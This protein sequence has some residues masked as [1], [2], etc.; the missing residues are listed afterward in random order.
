MLYRRELVKIQSNFS[1]K[2]K[3]VELQ[4]Q[5]TIKKTESAVKLG[6]RLLTFVQ[7]IQGGET[8]SQTQEVGWRL[9]TDK[10]LGL[11]EVPMQAISRYRKDP[12]QTFPI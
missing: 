6:E 8:G 12:V 1:V 2:T 10:S 4:K 3:S 9:Q 11:N 7:K 5:N